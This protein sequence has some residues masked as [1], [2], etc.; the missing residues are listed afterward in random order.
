MT[1]RSPS[2]LTYLK[3][4]A[5]AGL[6]ARYTFPDGSVIE[7]LNQQTTLTSAPTSPVND[8]AQKEIDDWDKAF[9]APH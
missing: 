9:G 7:I 1:K 6:S 8:A 2:P 3:K 4:L 5:E